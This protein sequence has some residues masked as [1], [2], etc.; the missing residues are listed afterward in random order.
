MAQEPAATN[1]FD[2]NIVSEKYS[3]TE[4][5]REERLSTVKTQYLA[6]LEKLYRKAIS[7]G[8]LDDVI[9][10]KSEKDRILTA[11]S[12]TH[13][14]RNALQ[15]HRRNADTTEKAQPVNDCV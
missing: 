7:K 1:G 6:V 4:S 8:D 9:A 10:V 3:D 2:L 5:L 15:F 13:M 12:L 14:F 11:V